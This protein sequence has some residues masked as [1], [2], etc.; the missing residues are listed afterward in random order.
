[1]ANQGC[2]CHVASQRQYVC[3]NVNLQ[4]QCLS[5]YKVDENL[6]GHDCLT[7]QLDNMTNRPSRSTNRPSKLMERPSTLMNKSSNSTNMED[8]H[9][10][11]H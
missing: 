3:H 11:F 2:L 7:K 4:P 1:M 10:E 9:N 6:D 5:R 8:G